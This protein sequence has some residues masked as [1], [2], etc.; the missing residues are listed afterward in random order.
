MDQKQPSDTA[1]GTGWQERLDEAR[2]QLERE[3]LKFDRQKASLELLLKRRELERAKDKGW[4]DLFANPLTLAIVGGFITL[5]TTTIASHLSTTASM[6]ADA[7]RESGQMQADAAR[8]SDELQTT[9]IEKFIDNPDPQTVRVNLQFL[10]D[11][12]LVPNYADNLKNFLAK[13][14]DSALPNLS[15]AA[16]SVLPTVHTQDDAISIIMRLEGGYDDDPN[17]P[18]G[19]SN[20]G[21]TLADLSQYIG[22]PV[23]KD[24]L[25]NLSAQTARAFY[26]S[27]FLVG[28]VP[29][30]VSPQVTAAYLHLAVNTGRGRAA[31]LF[32][33]AVANI[34]KLPEEYPAQM[35]TALVQRINAIDPNLLIET[36]NCQAAKYYESLPLFSH[37]GGYWIDTLRKFSPATLKGVC[38][39]L[40]MNSASTAPS[41]H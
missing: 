14:P 18:A 7:I 31:T 41:V 5:M 16:M 32:V 10:L 21:V 26:K 40:E 30:I 37:F 11:I 13:H 1:D 3:R 12:G 35:D 36:V 19:A 25:R 24:D 2:L 15:N 6:K 33:V 28:A 38:P 34:D 39:E 23:S 27:Q 17:D 20:F 9:L 8:A 22:K 4:K 29:S